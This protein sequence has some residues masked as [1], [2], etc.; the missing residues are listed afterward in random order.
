MNHILVVHIL[1]ANDHTSNHKF[2]LS[3]VKPLLLADVESQITTVEQVR[4]QIQI[5][6]VLKRVVHIDKD[7]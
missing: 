4:H 3:L 5:L 2:S 6:V 7:S 1:E